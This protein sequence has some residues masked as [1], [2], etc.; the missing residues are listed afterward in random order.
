VPLL[1]LATPFGRLN[2]LLCGIQ[3]GLHFIAA[4]PNAGK[5]CVEGQL[6][7][8]VASTSGP[9]LRIY[10]DDTHDDAMARSASRI[11]GVSLN[12]LQHGHI[13]PNDMKKIKDEVRPIIEAMPMYI[14]EDVESVEQIAVMARL[15]KAKY[16]IVMLTVDYVQ[17]VDVESE[18]RLML[19]RDRLAFVCKK[20]KKLWKELRIPILVL[21]QVQRENYKGDSNPRMAS[22]SELF[23]G[24]VLEHT[25]STVSILKML[26][27]TDVAPQPLDS[28]GYSMKYPVAWHL[29][30]S[31]HGPKGMIPLWFYP[32]YFKFMETP[33]YVK[34]SGKVPQ[35]YWKLWEEQLA[36]ERNNG[37]LYEE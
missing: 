22:M 27:D 36:D 1:G 19:E 37:Q 18:E 34:S 32:K 14:R 10:L 31:K 6:S 9:V 3:P 35:I 4:P 30:K 17:I 25:A 21:S 20:L 15:Y 7:E 13:Q 33:S 23:G 2:E 24:A 11:G 16:G 26:K 28:T 8:F 12:K 5:T 29:V